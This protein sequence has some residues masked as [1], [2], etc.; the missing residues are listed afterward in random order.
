MDTEPRIVKLKAIEATPESF[1][2]FGQVIGASPDGEEFGPQ[3]AQLEFNQ[4]I[5][6]FP[7]PSFLLSLLLPFCSLI[8]SLVPSPFCLWFVFELILGSSEVIAF[9]CCF[10]KWCYH[11]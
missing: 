6:R 1:G 4:G 8:A 9:S 3:D 7:G 2:E 5:P 10:W 11:F